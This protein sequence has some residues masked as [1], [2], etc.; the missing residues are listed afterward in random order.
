MN[1]FRSID[2]FTWNCLLQIN[3]K[4]NQIFQSII[5]SINNSPKEW[6]EFIESNSNL[7][8]LNEELEKSTNSFVKLMFLTIVKPQLF[9]KLNEEFINLNFQNMYKNLKVDLKKNLGDINNKKILLVIDDTSSSE[10][11]IIKLYNRKLNVEQAD[12]ILTISLK[13]EL[14][15]EDLNKIT[16]AMKFGNLTI[17]KESHWINYSFA[18]LNELMTDTKSTIHENFRLIMISKSNRNLSRS[19]FENCNIINRDYYS[20]KTLKDYIIDILENL[21]N[22]LIEN[23]VN[24]KKNMSFARKIFFHLLIVHSVIKQYYFYDTNLYYIPFEFNKKDLSN[25]FFFII[26]FIKNFDKDKDDVQNYITLINLVFEVFYAGRLIYKED[27]NRVIKLLLRYFEEEKFSNTNFYFY[28]TKNSKLNIKADDKDLTYEEISKLLNDI[29]I[30]S[31]YNL[32]ENISPSLIKE[33]LIDIPKNFFTVFNKLYGPRN[34]D[35]ENYHSEIETNWKF[36]ELLEKLKDIKK[37]LPTPI[38]IEGEGNNPNFMKMNKFGDVLNPMDETLKREIIMYNNYL[39]IVF[40]DIENMI[41]IYNGMF[42]YN[43]AYDFML[44]TIAKNQIPSNW[45]KQCFPINIEKVKRNQYSLSDWI[46]DFSERID[47]G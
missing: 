11:E 9:G 26:Q 10:L 34:L 2:N 16:N 30:D 19:H 42:I 32:L 5:E 8:L 1:N 4:T 18:R 15:E 46:K 24:Q 25:S 27:F 28:F 12:S 29:P 14:T 7:R 6:D 17:L 35:H 37:K 43:E 33:K 3:N 45:I 21:D 41:K 13:G 22:F 20:V 44:Q 38:N 39:K 40:L 31:Y 36:N 23:M 47:F